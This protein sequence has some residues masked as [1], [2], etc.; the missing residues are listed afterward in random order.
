[1]LL[2]AMPFATP[3]QIEQ[4]MRGQCA[5]RRC[6]GPIPPE[7]GI[8]TGRGRV[9]AYRAAI[10]TAWRGGYAHDREQGRMMIGRTRASDALNVLVEGGPSPVRYALLDMTGRAM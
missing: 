9:N 4:A 10:G 5:H 6:A 8:M 3:A 2:E 1:M 7:G